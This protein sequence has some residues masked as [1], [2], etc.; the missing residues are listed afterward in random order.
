MRI[1]KQLIYSFG[2]SVLFLLAHMIM[3]HL[4]LS[5][6]LNLILSLSMML[7]IQL[8]AFILLKNNSSI[9]Q[10]LKY[11]NILPMLCYTQAFAIILL[12]FNS[13]FNPI[14]VMKPLNLVEIFTSLLIFAL[15][16]PVVVTTIIWLALRKK[17]VP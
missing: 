16:F 1:S 6:S 17:L 12:S 7:L 14:G 3:E 13:A 2:I 4:K 5:D 8:F 15:I 11:S 9:G 10:Q